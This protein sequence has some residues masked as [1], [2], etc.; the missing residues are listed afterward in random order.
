MNYC[1]F[2]YF[3]LKSNKFIFIIFIDEIIYNNYW[4]I[5]LLWN[6]QVKNQ[7]LFSLLDIFVF[8]YCIKYKR[9]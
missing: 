4:P 1:Q 3:G 9:W 2:F 7:N 6:I 5:P 8:I